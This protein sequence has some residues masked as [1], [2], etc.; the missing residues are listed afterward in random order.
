MGRAHSLEELRNE[1]LEVLFGSWEYL[2]NHGD[3]E[4]IL[5]LVGRR[6]NCVILKRKEGRS[7]GS[8][9]HLNAESSA[10]LA[11]RPG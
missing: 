7:S 6:T 2:E 4:R 11:A 5:L 3:R 10:G 8:V 9:D 1:E